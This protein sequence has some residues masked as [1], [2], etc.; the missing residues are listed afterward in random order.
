[1]HRKTQRCWTILLIVFSL[2]IG[3]PTFVK[4]APG[5]KPS[6][7]SRNYYVS[8]T[9]SDSN[10]GTLES[11]FKTFTR[12]VSSLAPGDTLIILPGVYNQILKISQ[13]GKPGAPII[14]QGA[15]A[16]IDLANSR[17]PAV[18]VIG[19][20]IQVIGLEVRRVDGICVGLFGNNVILSKLIV[21]ECTSHGINTEYNAH[22]RI[23]NSRVYLTVLQNR[24]RNLT[25]GWAS[26]IKAASA[27]L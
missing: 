1:M 5:S 11:P 26:A 17:G 15:G 4:A 20:Y 24:A 7:L 21:H 25:S 12:A 16:V 27:W 23:L 13:S 3:N 9:G 10:A 18:K 14:I 19:S 6:A 8:T 22:I 2:A